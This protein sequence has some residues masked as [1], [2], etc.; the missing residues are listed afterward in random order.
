M[1]SKI[2]TSHSEF[3]EYKFNKELVFD[4]FW[5]NVRSPR[6]SSLSIGD[7][8]ESIVSRVRP[9]YPFDR[10]GK[11]Q[12]VTGVGGKHPH[13]VALVHG[14]G[15]V[16]QVPHDKDRL[17]EEVV[18]AGLA[19]V[20]VLEGGVNGEQGLEGPDGH[21]DHHHDGEDGDGVA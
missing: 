20:Q 6:M 2:V 17:V 4:H 9:L 3:L 21:H 8:R 13:A 15:D 19:G 11:S 14:Q 18:A 7:K 16:D 12:P 1:K 10:V 5:E